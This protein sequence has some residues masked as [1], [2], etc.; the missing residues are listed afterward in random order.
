MLPYWQEGVKMSR[1]IYDN[2]DT[3]RLVRVFRA[4]ENIS[5]QTLADRC[6]VKR[7]TISFIETEQLYLVSYERIEHIINCISAFNKTNTIRG[8]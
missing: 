8:N 3:S 6:R 5:Q 4:H 2:A 7:R 1:G